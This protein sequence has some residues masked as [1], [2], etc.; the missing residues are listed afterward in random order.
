MV[1][2]IQDLLLLHNQS[3][4]W[5]NVFDI[6]ATFQNCLTLYKLSSGCAEA[7]RLVERVLNH[8]KVRNV[9]DEFEQ[10]ILIVGGIER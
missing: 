9:W 4:S 1:E 8:Q 3:K 6:R 7:L 5:S 10:F 2:N